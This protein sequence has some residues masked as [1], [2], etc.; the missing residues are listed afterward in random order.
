MIKNGAT[1][2]EVAAALGIKDVASL[3]HQFEDI[4]RARD[5]QEFADSLKPQSQ[6]S[7]EEEE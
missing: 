7:E 2:E 3:A 4:L 6:Q 1:I 5:M